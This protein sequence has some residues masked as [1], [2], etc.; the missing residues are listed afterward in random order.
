MNSLT[1]H[2]ANGPLPIGQ[3]NSIGFGSGMNLNVTQLTEKILTASVIQCHAAILSNLYSR[4]CDI[5]R[6]FSF[7]FGI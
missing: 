5:M 2:Q 4:F 3:E 6:A 7:I 1:L